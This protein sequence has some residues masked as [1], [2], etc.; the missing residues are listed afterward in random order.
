[1]F[2]KPRQIAMLNQAQCNDWTLGVLMNGSRWR[3]RHTLTPFFTLGLAAY[4]DAVSPQGD[5][6]CQSDRR[7]SNQFLYSQFQ[8]L[9]E[10][11]AQLLQVQLQKAVVLVE[12]QAALPGFHVYLPHLGFTSEAASIHP[13]YRKSLCPF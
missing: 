2:A 12:S 10:S 11:L 9:Y 6:Y 3:Q 4:L 8:Y 7:Q 13:E 1:M 5:Y